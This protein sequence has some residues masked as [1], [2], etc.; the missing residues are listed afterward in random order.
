ML[1]SLSCAKRLARWVIHILRYMGINQLTKLATPQMI[2]SQAVEP[3]DFEIRLGRSMLTQLV[4]YCQTYVEA[5]SPYHP[6]GIR[7]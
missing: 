2:R 1:S 5:V 7:V 6:Q 4:S 3:A